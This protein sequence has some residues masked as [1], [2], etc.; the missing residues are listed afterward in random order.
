MKRLA[1]CLV[2]AGCA[3]TPSVTPVTSAISTAAQL[4]TAALTA[5]V[6]LANSKAISSAQLSKVVAVTNGVEAALVLAEQAVNAG[7]Q[8]TAQ[9]KLNAAMATVSALTACLAPKSISQ[10]DACIAGVQAP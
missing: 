10:V 4:N 6:S 5:A 1:L 7:N 3:S 2:L 9:E 8:A